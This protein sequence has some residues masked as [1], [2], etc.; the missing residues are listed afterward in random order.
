MSQT[1]Q[2]AEGQRAGAGSSAAPGTLDS[3][4][5]QY[6][7]SLIAYFQRRRFPPETAE[8]LTQEVF[9]RLAKRRMG[10]VDNPEAYLFTTA[11]SVIIDHGRRAKVRCEDAHDPIDDFEVESGVPTPARVFA[12]KEALQRVAVILDELPE[13]TREVFVLSRLEGLTNTQL[14]ARYGISVSSI[15]KH[16]TRALAHIRNRFHGDG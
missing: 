5:K 2:D 9:A 14:A 4:A 13:R 8:D 11:S 10:G 16:M 1:E 7:A 3:L 15:E 12:G 6:R